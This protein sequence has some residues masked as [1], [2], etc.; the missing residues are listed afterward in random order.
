MFLSVS[1]RD[2]SGQPGVGTVQFTIMGGTTFQV[3]QTLVDGVAE[4]EFGSTSFGPEPGQETVDPYFQLP[5]GF[6]IGAL[7]VPADPL[8]QA[9]SSGRADLTITPATPTVSGGWGG[10]VVSLPV[11]GTIELKAV[12]SAPPVEGSYTL[13]DPTG[14]VD[15]YLGGVLVASAP[16]V[17]DSTQPD[18]VSGASA[19]A[20]SQ[21][22]GEQKLEIVY[23]GDTNYSAA[24]SGSFPGPPFTQAPGPSPELASTG[25]DSGAG[26]FAGSVAAGVVLG[27]LGLVL[28]RRGDKRRRLS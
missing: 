10:D 20:T 6:D 25:T 15:F 26:L 19:L 27:G 8:V 24:R 9:P 12:V 28:L 2:E 1:V 18:G 11:G 23:S 5:P 13:L 22:A 3:P 16:L 21:T 14:S 7:F 17:Q 4:V